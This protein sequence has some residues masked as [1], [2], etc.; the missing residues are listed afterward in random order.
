MI[1]LVGIPFE[2]FHTLN[3]TTKFFYDP[4]EGNLLLN[5]TIF[6]QDNISDG[7]GFDQSDYSG[8]QT[9]RAWAYN[10]EVSGYSDSLGL[11]TSFNGPVIMPEPSSLLL[12]AG[13][14]VGLVG[15]LRRKARRHRI[16]R[17]QRYPGKPIRW[18]VVSK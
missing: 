8:N 14:L 17:A 11:V 18:I 1:P 7:I 4:V 13:G 3:N 16:G 5:I 2:T 15:T 12:I 9:S 10:G 6:D